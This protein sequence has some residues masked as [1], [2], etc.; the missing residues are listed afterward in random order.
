[1]WIKFL[2]ILDKFMTWCFAIINNRPAEIYFEKKRD[3]T[4]ITGHCYAKREEFDDEEERQAFDE[5]TAKYKFSYRRGEY[6]RT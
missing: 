4:E 3:K 2:L 1:M 6:R 5:D